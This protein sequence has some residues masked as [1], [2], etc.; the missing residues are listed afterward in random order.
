MFGVDCPLRRSDCVVIKHV[1]IIAVINMRVRL[2]CASECECLEAGS[3]NN[4]PEC[5]SATGMC[6]C[7][8]NVQG[9]NCDE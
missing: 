6:T 2:L 5:S 4:D 7:K 1:I 3:R 8:E 9:Q